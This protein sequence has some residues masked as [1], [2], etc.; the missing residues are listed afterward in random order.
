M[1]HMLIL[2]A[3]QAFFSKAFGCFDGSSAKLC[4][5]PCSQYRSTFL[6]AGCLFLRHDFFGQLANLMGTVFCEGIPEG[7]KPL[8]ETVNCVTCWL[9]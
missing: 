4:Q 6:R 1:S 8:A 2:E 7:L 9:L 3:G 5:G